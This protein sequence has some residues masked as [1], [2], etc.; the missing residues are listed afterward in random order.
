MSEFDFDDEDNVKSSASKKKKTSSVIKR[1]RYKSPTKSAK[2]S[3]PRPAGISGLSAKKSAPKSA[4]KSAPKSAKKSAP[5]SAKKSPPKSARTPRRDVVRNTSRTA[6][7][8][9]KRKPTSKKWGTLRRNYV[10]GRD[11]PLKLSPIMES[12]ITP[13]SK[14]KRREK[15]YV[16][17]G[18][19]LPKTPNRMRKS[20]RV[21]FWDDLVGSR[22]KTK[23]SKRTYG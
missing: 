7:R 6:R 23:R 16:Q 9:Y 10:R 12:P 3:A 8:S 1:V 22:R 18:E 5:K 4:K 17:P 21:D 11:L 2:R 19:E 14:M 20:D 15:F 13:I